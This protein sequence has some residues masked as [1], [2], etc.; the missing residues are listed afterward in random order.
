[1]QHDNASITRR[2]SSNKGCNAWLGKKFNFVSASLDM[3]EQT[4]QIPYG[5]SSVKPAS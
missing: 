1:M 3:L 2:K 5:D 4:L